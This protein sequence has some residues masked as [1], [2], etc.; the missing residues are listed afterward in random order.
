MAIG[1]NAI[2]K[3][4]PFRTLNCTDKDFETRLFGNPQFPGAPHVSSEFAAA[5]GGT[6]LLEEVGCLSPRLQSRL[7]SMLEDR[8][9]RTRVWKEGFD[10]RVIATTE[11]NLE[12]A[13]T[14]GRFRPDLYFRLNQGLIR[15]PSV[16][17]RKPSQPP[18]NGK[19]DIRKRL[20]SAA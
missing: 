8:R 6:L 11:C 12:L 13:V 19:P 5:N 3:E 9:V 16:R 4:R 15:L 1:Q 20:R 2:L 17:G 7:R 10:V 18:V 14:E